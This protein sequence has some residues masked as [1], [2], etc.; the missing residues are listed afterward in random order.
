MTDT[1]TPPPAKTKANRVLAAFMSGRSYN[2]FEAERHLHDH[3]LHSTVAGLQPRHHITIS[4]KFETVLGYR[5]NP[6]RCCRYWISL[7]ERL[8][9]ERRRANTA[10]KEAPNSDQTERGLQNVHE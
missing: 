6:T 3:C 10:Q 7:E 8:R 2:R 5:G 1:T 4:R 9:I